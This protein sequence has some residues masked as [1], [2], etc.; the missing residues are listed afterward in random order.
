MSKKGKKEK[1]K[2]KTEDKIFVLNGEFLSG[3]ND[4][5]VTDLAKYIDEKITGKAKRDGTD[6]LISAKD[7]TVSKTKLRI[8]IKKFLHKNDIDKTFKIISLAGKGNTLIIKKQ[9]EVIE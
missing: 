9:K 6:V 5:L 7:K 8:L 4:V 2:T 3:Y 1:T